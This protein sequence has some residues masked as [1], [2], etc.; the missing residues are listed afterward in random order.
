M[1]LEKS[2]ARSL[3][4]LLLGA[5]LA[6][7]AVL[8]VAAPKALPE[9]ESASCAAIPKASTAMLQMRS[10]HSTDSTDAFQE[11][12]AMEAAETKACTCSESHPYCWKKDGYCYLSSSSPFWSRH[13]R[14]TCTQDYKK[15]ESRPEA[16][17]CLFHRFKAIDAEDNMILGTKANMDVPESLGID[18]RGLWWMWGNPVPEILSSF[19]GTKSN[20]SSYPVAL[21]IKSRMAHHW[22]FPDSIFGKG[23]MAF[24]NLEHE[25]TELKAE[26]TLAIRFQNSTHGEID[27]RLRNIP[28][29]WGDRW[30]MYKINNDMWSRPSTFQKGSV[31]PDTTYNLTRIIREDGTKTRYWKDFLA[32]SDNVDQLTYGTNDNC[33]RICRAGGTS[34]HFCRVTCGI[35]R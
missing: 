28:L 27:N 31:L 20:G 10:T 7:G 3:A 19:A 26:R 33:V 35:F 8:A 18:L 5:V 32:S 6:G 1:S 15:G 17:D 30:P 11:E 21:F 14:G 25:G 23:F 16:N 22:S 4:R 13:C 2:A 24:N 9:L 12:A 29:V 34:C